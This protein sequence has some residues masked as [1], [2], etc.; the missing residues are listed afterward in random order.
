MQLTLTERAKLMEEQMELFNDG[1][2]KDQGGTKEPESGNDVPSGALKKEVADDIPIMISEGEFVFPADVVRYLGLSTLMKMRQDAKQGLK[3]MEKMGQMGNPEEAELPDDIPFE[4]AD[5]IVVSGDM[6]E[7][8]DDKE[9][10]AE[11]GIVGLQSGGLFDDP[12]FADQRGTTPPPTLNDEDKKEIEDAL[13]GTVYGNI[14]MKRYVDANGNVKYIPFIDNEPQM[15][16][17]EGYT[18]DESA[19]VPTSPVS[20]GAGRAESSGRVSTPVASTDEVTSMVRESFARQG[21][22]KFN[23]TGLSPEELVDYYGTFSGATNRFLSIGV[24]ALFGGIPAVGI[25][26]MQTLS[27]NKGPNSLRATEALLAR[28]VS[29]GKITGKLL[30]TLKEFQKRAADKGTGAGGFIGKLIDKLFPNDEEKKNELQEAIGNGD[31]NKVRAV[32]GTST[33]DTSPEVAYQEYVNDASDF[34]A[35]EL[36]SE[37]LPSSIINARKEEVESSMFPS[38]PPARARAER[39]KSEERARADFDFLGGDYDRPQPS[40]SGQPLKGSGVDIGL[41]EALRPQ[42][43]EDQFRAEDVEYRMYPAD[44]PARAKTQEMAERETKKR[45]KRA[46]MDLEFLGGETIGGTVNTK[47]RTARLEKERQAKLAQEK[48]KKKEEPKPAPTPT[49]IPAHSPNSR[50]N[51]VRQDVFM[52][53][54]DAFAADRAYHQAFTGFDSSGNYTPFYVGGVPTK[55]MKPQRLKKGGL[56][57]RKKK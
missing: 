47:K 18:L 4:M 36:R 1:G 50:E 29:E 53:T 43:R 32:A 34:D 27:Q 56:A 15:A 55:P 20:S 24:G 2:L 13:L 30:T 39:L 48:K 28:M 57:S 44:P 6:K 40:I 17:P 45:E 9:K 49:Q 16:I 11:G 37:N 3:M 10:K 19:P 23:I 12:R 25:A 54:G 51:Q 35:D 22:A 33:A 5:L 52:Q 7:G 46:K 41:Q 42:E 21:E 8:K 31:V 38:D 26:A 14:T